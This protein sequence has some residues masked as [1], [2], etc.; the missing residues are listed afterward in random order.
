MT[1][2]IKQ[3]ILEG[4]TNLVEIDDSVGYLDK[5]EVWDLGGCEKH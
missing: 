2:N 1:P 4:C 5:L 3:L